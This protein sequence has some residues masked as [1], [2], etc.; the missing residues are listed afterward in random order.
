MSEI[1][2]HRNAFVALCS[3]AAKEIWCWKLSCTTCGH[4][5]F[6]YGFM[7]LSNGKHP[8]SPDWIVSS[9]H[10]SELHGS[11]GP[12][13]GF[14]KRRDGPSKEDQME[15]ICVL[16]G[17][18]IS[19][20]AKNCRFPGWLGYLGLALSYT[21]PIESESKV[22]TAAWVPQLLEL[23]PTHTSSRKLLESMLLDPKE[24]QLRWQHLEQVEEDLVVRARMKRNNLMSLS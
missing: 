10:H 19:Q 1:H 5:Y 15:L 18:S 9:N 2:F 12:A 21:E 20:I 14:S 6:R 11:L 3:L 22:L 23:L 13:W 7:E 17:A 24:N 4:G 16:S 8:D